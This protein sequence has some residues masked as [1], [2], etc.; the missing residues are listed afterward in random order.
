MNLK[1]VNETMASLEDEA[2]DMLYDMLHSVINGEYV[3]Y[4]TV[5]ERF[6]SVHLNNID[7]LV[8]KLTDEVMNNGLEHLKF[9]HG[10]SIIK[11]TGS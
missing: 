11:Q 8:N 4:N 3:L 7:L 5:N 10:S 2:K 9:I 1:E 6:V